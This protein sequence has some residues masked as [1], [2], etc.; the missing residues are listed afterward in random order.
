M[1]SIR[2]EYQ[3]FD[4][5][6]GFTKTSKTKWNALPFLKAVTLVVTALTV[7]QII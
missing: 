2:N 7:S 4:C 1:R 5:A 3:A 6:G